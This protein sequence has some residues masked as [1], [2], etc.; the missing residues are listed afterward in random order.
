MGKSGGDIETEW[1]GR[2]EESGWR[3]VKIE[4]VI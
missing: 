4:V 1:I 2:V 3:E